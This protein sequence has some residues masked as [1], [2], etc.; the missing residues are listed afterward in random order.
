MSSTTTANNPSSTTAATTP[1]HQTT[2]AGPAILPQS[3]ST[4]AAATSLVP[5]SPSSAKHAA[6]AAAA[7]IVSPLLNPLAASAGVNQSRSLG[8]RI[9]FL[10]AQLAHA[11]MPSI[12]SKRRS[13]PSIEE[14]WNLPIS[15]EMSSRQQQQSAAAQTQHQRAFAKSGYQQVSVVGLF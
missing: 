6:A 7:S 13:L 5:S 8:H 11:P 15:A 4:A 2:P 1:N 12:T 10:K 14:A 3:A 9:A